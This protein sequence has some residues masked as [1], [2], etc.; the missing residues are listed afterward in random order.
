MTKNQRTG[1]AV[2]DAFPGDLLQAFLDCV[3]QR[4]RNAYVK[5]ATDESQAK[6]LAGHFS[7]FDT[8]PAQN[9]LA[10][11]KDYTARLNELLEPAPFSS[12]AAGLGSIDLGVMLKQAVARGGA[13][14]MQATCRFVLGFL[15]V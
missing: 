2:F 3:I 6:R 1:R 12:K 11:L 4:R 15:P 5:T 14:T 7:Q 10:G 13:I 8:D 9:A